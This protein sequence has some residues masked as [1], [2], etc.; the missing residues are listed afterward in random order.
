M[1]EEKIRLKGEKIRWQGNVK[2]ASGIE[3]YIIRE[4]R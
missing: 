4:L 2:G 1:T 3:S